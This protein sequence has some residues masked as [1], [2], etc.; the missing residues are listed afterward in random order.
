M[1][2]HTFTSSA[3][4]V[5]FAGVSMLALVAPFELTQPL[6]RLPR[7]S[8]S[9]LEAALLLALGSWSVAL[10]WTHAVPRWQTPLSA[11]WM[12]LIAVLFSASIAAPA[13]RVNALHMTGRCAAAFACFLLT[14]NGVTTRRR[15]RVV[16]TLT[17]VAAVAV[18]LLACLEYAGTAW[19]LDV[20]KLFR[21]GITVVGAQLRAAGPLQYPTIASMYLEVAFALSLGLLLTT[22]D[23]ARPGRLVML[24]VAVVLVAEAIT[25]TFTRAGVITMAASVILVAAVRHRLRGYDAGTALILTIGVI[26]SAL[27]LSSR[28]AE[29]MWL[30]LTSE[31]QESW[32]RAHISSPEDLVFSTG[33]TETV[34]VTL[35]NTGRLTWD[36]HAEAPLILSYHWLPID[37]NYFITFEGERTEFPEPVA[38][39]AT[40]TLFAK[41]RTPRQPGRYR[42]EWDIA[43]EGR[44]WFSTEPG[45]TRLFW[46]V[47][48]TGAALGGPDDR[49]MLPPRP[50]VRPGRLVLWRAAIRMVAAHPLLGVGP[51]NFRLSYGDYAGIKAADPRLHSNNMYLEVL[52]GSGLLGGAAFLWFLWRTAVV[53]VRIAAFEAGI[54]AAG[55]AVAIHGVVDSFL[56]FAPTYLLFALTLGLAVASATISQGERDAHRV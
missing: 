22:L 42:L 30:R 50:T 31:G 23:A 15:L 2:G 53:L 7:Q 1:V 34:P 54:A 21:P 37:A 10:V 8:V 55:L 6:I 48:V 43:Q 40:L 36:S 16:V 47:T 11:P 20:L 38:P 41:V 28:S 18:S 17:I 49:P 32:Y 29:S 12:A 35:T 19:V 45:A 39:G 3:T 56:S 9:N 51:D 46:P 4:A 33:R 24:C 26:V 52:A 25:L 27:F 44:L 5:A 14:V 13:A